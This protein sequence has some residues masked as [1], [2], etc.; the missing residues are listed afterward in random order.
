MEIGPMANFV[1][2]LGDPATKTAAVVDPAWDVK[3]IIKAA[4]DDGYRITRILLTHGH[5]DHA[6]GVDEL[7][8]TTGAE[9]YAHPAESF[10]LKDLRTKIR[11][12]EGGTISIGEISVSVI[13][14]PG[15]SAG[16]VCLIAGENF[17]TG[18]TL[19]VGAC[20]RTDLPGGSAKELFE[21][22]QKIRQLDDSLI[23]CPGHHY[24]PECTSTL[25]M[26]K[27]GNSFLATRGLNNFLKLASPS[28][29]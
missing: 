22:F 12:Y 18:D 1:Y 26:E 11:P 3:R 16:S 2:L 23:L 14:T 20:G 9:V 29:V 13:H 15:H 19:F 24:G 25:G 4:E 28:V 5:P 6:N 10:W 27:Q 8:S 7:A 21:S 17:L